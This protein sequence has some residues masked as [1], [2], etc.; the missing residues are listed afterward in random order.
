MVRFLTGDIKERYLRDT[1]IPTYTKRRDFMAK[2]IEEY[3]PEARTVIPDGAFYF[4]VDMGKYFSVMQRTDDQ[5][6]D[7]LLKLKGVVV[8]PGSYFGEKGV[9]HIRLTFVSEPEERIDVGM[10]RLGEY[11]FSY[12]F[13]MAK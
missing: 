2:A 11:V 7:R 12:A 8:I 4:L 5:F 1:V 10:R 6:C 13:S 9:G 3:L